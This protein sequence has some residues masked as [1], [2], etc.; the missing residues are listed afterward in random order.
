[1]LRPSQQEAEKEID[2]DIQSDDEN[3]SFV[4]TSWE[5]NWTR[6]SQILVHGVCK[7]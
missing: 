4:T 3:V 7:S 1:M 2:L 6:V 5:D